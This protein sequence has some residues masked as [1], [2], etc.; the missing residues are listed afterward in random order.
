MFEW[1]KYFCCC[2]KMKDDFYQV[3]L[4]KT[5]WDIPKR[6]GNLSPVGSGAYGQVK[7]MHLINTKKT[8]DYLFDE[9]I[10]NLILSHISLCRFAALKTRKVF[11]K[12]V[13]QV[14]K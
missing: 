3:E 12:I 5:T 1:L 14:N 2:S 8:G 13:R 9:A 7:T 11:T 10:N 4:N 6:Y